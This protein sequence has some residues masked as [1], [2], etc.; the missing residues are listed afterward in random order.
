[1]KIRVLTLGAGQEVG[2]SCVVVYIGGKTVMFD[3][4]MHMGYQD[5]RRF[6]DFRMV[7]RNGNYTQ[8]VDAVIVTHFHLDHC[9][10][11]PYFT[12]VCG[13]DGPVFMTY[14]TRAIVPVMLEDFRKVLVDRRGEVELFSNR[15]ISDSMKKV[16][17]V[18]LHE[19]V[20]IG[21]DMEIRAYYAGHVLGAAMFYLRVGTES[22]VYTG[23]YNMTPDRHLGAAY[24][25]RLR[26]D[27]LVTETTYGTSIR[28]SK[29]ARERDFLTQVH[30]TVANG[31]K[32]LIPVFA[33]GRAQ[34]LCILLDEYWE[35]MNLDVP[36]YLSAGMTSKA[37]LYY[38]LLVSW[39]SEKVKTSY[40]ERNAFGFGRMQQWDRSLVDR[41]GPCILFATPG[42][43]HGGTS[44]E[45]FKRWATSELNMVILPG[46]CVAG[47]VGNKLLAGG[48]GK[49]IDVD[50]RTKLSV[51]CKVRYLSFSA[52]A[53]AKGIMRLVQ[54][55]APRHVM[56]VHGER[57]RMEFLAGKI[58]K[59]FRVRVFM[60]PNGTTVT[61]RT[62]A[63]VPVRVSRRLASEALKGV[64][65]RRAQ[66]R[67]MGA[68][69]E[70]TS[71]AAVRG[72]AARWRFGGR[73]RSRRQGGEGH[74]RDGDRSP[75]AR[76]AEGAAEDDSPAQKR[77][78][79][80]DAECNDSSDAAVLK[81][82]EQSLA[83]CN[84]GGQAVSVD[85]ERGLVTV[86]SFEAL[87]QTK[88]VIQ[89]E[90]T[91]LQLSCSWLQD[92]EEL[93]HVCIEALR[94]AFCPLGP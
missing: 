88:E 57:S 38:K 33:L 83:R 24:I 58:G 40:A 19:T 69:P 11:L 91:H 21:E 20:R 12:E 70:P 43:L 92:D 49:A 85:L 53:D 50:K 31:G 81:K 51:A 71:R 82:A 94:E 1:M 47:T 25:D 46:Y 84:L 29:R 80:D 87:L 3:C 73:R 8:A 67:A 26:P 59:T 66:R 23:D 28:D 14:P 48:N 34:E 9:G 18:N 42:M 45:V 6:P 64:S 86:G 65:E 39:T 44:L 4:G 68:T 15:H 36:I 93:A 72:R 32:V 63:A 89:D 10:A 17:C 2:R 41:P 35:R 74:A 37:N 16:R 75:S 5:E 52:H 27:L 7:S 78:R 56:L 61:M 55:C 90:E 54:Q 62:S 30:E 60:P 13:Y 79:T 77:A 22:V 76:V